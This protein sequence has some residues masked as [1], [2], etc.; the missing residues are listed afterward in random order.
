MK[1]RNIIK[2]L[3][4]A[5]M[6][7]SSIPSFAQGTQRAI[8]LVNE[9]LDQ[10]SVPNLAI[11][12]FEAAIIQDPMMVDAYFYLGTTHLR[13]TG[14]IESAFTALERARGLWN[15]QGSRKIR[16]ES[17]EEINDELDYISTKF[18]TLRIK[19]KKS[20]IDRLGY[21]D[22]VRLKFK[23]PVDLDNR[24]KLRIAYLEGARSSDEFQFSNKDRRDDKLFFEIK[25]FPARAS[26]ESGLG[27][28][29]DVLGS[30][31]RRYRFDLTEDDDEQLLEFRWSPND[32][33]I[34]ERVPI[35]LIKIEYPNNY[36]FT[37]NS[38]D[39]FSTEQK[40]NYK[41]IYIPVSATDLELTLIGSTERDT[42][43]MFKM[44]NS[45]MIMTLTASL[46][47]LVR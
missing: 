30:N 42:E 23:F 44:F 39:A 19:L 12:K 22:G 34:I 20:N 9:G 11:R 29:I 2:A 33:K 21:I 35:D 43:N 16:V 5:A 26:G 10:L 31:E 13:G 7:F 6:V 32:W 4:F 25:Y 18:K 8:Q 38:G 3:V 40:D 28:I 14:N 27:Y 46:F 36:N 45:V 24:Q 1:T 41:N 15:S 17:L 37:S 47:I